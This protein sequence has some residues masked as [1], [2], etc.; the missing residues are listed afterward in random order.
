MSVG[1]PTDP[2]LGQAALGGT[3][4]SVLGLF[5]A[6]GTS[7]LVQIALARLLAPEVFGVVGMAI[8]FTTIMGTIGD[9]GP[10]CSANGWTVLKPRCEA[11]IRGGKRGGN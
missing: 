2:Q 8:V 7:A 10:W 6:R 3:L 4:W 5:A 1:K 9:R 11:K